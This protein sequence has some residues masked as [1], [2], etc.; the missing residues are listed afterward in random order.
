MTIAH[1]LLRAAALI[2]IALGEPGRVGTLEEDENGDVVFIEASVEDEINALMDEAEEARKRTDLSRQD[3]DD[4]LEKVISLG[5]EALR[6][7]DRAAAIMPLMRDRVL[8]LRFFAR[9]DRSKVPPKPIALM[10][11]MFL[12]AVATVWGAE[13]VDKLTFSFEV[14]PI[15]GDVL[16][17]LSFWP[18]PKAVAGGSTLISPAG[19]GSYVLIMSP[20][21]LREDE[22]TIR[23]I[24]IHEAVHIG[25]VGHGA[26]FQRVVKRH[27]GALSERSA[28]EGRVHV[29]EKVGARYKT[30]ET[31]AD[32]E[33]AK[34]RLYAL[35]RANPGKQYRIT[36]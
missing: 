25:Y 36:Y 8:D 23:K 34:A 27:G 28:V 18:R 1:D 26:E 31:F 13:W 9:P 15:K 22:D 30:I 2:E 35:G 24:M 4:A 17:A 20:R 14:R 3:A 19:D 10:E 6:N 16:A 12:D 7:P 21:L 33:R 5:V 11:R 32:M 29:Q